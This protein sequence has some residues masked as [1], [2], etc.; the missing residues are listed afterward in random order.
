M[1]KQ[2]RWLLDS[3]SPRKGPKL[4]KDKLHNAKDYPREVIDEWVR[5]RAAKY[6]D[7]PS[8]A[9]KSKKGE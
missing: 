6:E 3:S 7:S 2:F 8:E 5:T 4:E 9:K 1:A